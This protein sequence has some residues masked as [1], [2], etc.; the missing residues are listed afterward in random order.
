MDLDPNDDRSDTALQ[1]GTADAPAP[2]PVADPAPP[3]DPR[4]AVFDIADFRA[5]ASFAGIRRE[6]RG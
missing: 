4:E 1:S 2:P 5:L 3:P 6:R